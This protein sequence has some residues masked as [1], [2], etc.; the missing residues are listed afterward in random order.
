MLYN[1]HKLQK[2]AIASGDGWR[3]VQDPATLRITAHGPD[4][5]VFHLVNVKTPMTRENMNL[6]FMCIERDMF[7]P[8]RPYPV[9]RNQR[10]YR[11]LCALYLGDEGRKD[12]EARRRGIYH[13]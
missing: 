8:G 5:E 7:N 6:L 9:L 12:K 3:L 10:N 11:I 13:A 2:T 4:G 1:Y